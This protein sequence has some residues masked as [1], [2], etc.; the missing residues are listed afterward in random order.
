MSRRKASDTNG[1]VAELLKDGGIAIREILAQVFTDILNPESSIPSYWKQTRLKVLF[2]QGDPQ[3]PNN[4]RPISI[5]PILYKLFSR[6]V[7]SRI[8]GVLMSAQSC[9]QAGFRP[10]YCCDDHLFA[11]SLLAEK[12]NEFSRPLWVV[13]VDFVKAFD[14]IKHSSLWQSL[15]EQDVPLVY[16]NCLQRLYAEQQ[17]YVQCDAKSR[18][19]K[20]KKGTKQ[21]DPISPILFNAALE[22]AM[23]KAK[24]KWMEKKWGVQL[25]YGKDGILTNLR[26]A[27]DVLL[28]G[29]SLFQAQ[30][31][32]KDLII[33]A[34]AVGLEIHPGKTCIM[35]NGI[36]QGQGAQSVEVDGKEVKVLARAE[37]TKYLGRLLNLREPTDVEINFRI[38]RAWAKFAVYKSELTDKHYSL[39]QRLRL[40]NAVVTPTALYGASSWAM[41][42][43]REQTLR[44]AQRKLL[45]SILGQGRKSI[46][47]SSSSIDSSSTSAAEDEEMDEGETLE[48]WVQ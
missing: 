48:S 16:I 13:A 43:A 4:Y 1:L 33:Q 41:T 3:M 8:H 23:A 20:I 38:Q 30:E 47:S 7:C 42:A 31:M 21:G 19:L 12:M 11:V 34:R 14:T 26:F 10:G 27:D 22:K 9:D 39:F 44:T 35:N 40:F 46:Q 36:G 6:I 5:L 2:K 28:V 25:G 29:R 15:L 24:Q 45:Q 17:G 18:L 37:S 32:L